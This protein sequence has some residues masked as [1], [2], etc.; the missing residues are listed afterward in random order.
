MIK[1]DRCSWVKNQPDIYIE[2]HDEEWGVPVHD[3]RLLF[4]KLVLDGA[5]AGLSW[6]TILKK[7]QSYFEAFDNFDIKT[8]SEYEERKIQE[9]MQNPGIIRNRL[10]I[11]AAVKNASAILEIQKEFGSFNSYLWGFTDNKTI[12]NNFTDIGEVPVK[13]LLSEVI[14]KDMKKRGMAFVGPTIIYAYMQAIGM[15]NDHTTNCFRHRELKN[16]KKPDNLR[17]L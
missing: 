10:K 1:I 13:T 6:L 14:S 12:T 8:V 17:F 15:V 9:L 7:K 5:Q 2:Y 3:D 4:A 16:E 11:E